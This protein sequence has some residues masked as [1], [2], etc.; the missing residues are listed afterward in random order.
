MHTMGCKPSVIDTE[1][2]YSIDEIRDNAET[3][4]L[5]LF[6][7]KGNISNCVRLFSGSV[8]SHV[9]I[10][11]KSN[12]GEVYIFECAQDDKFIDR[13]TGV[14]K[15][16]ARLVRFDDMLEMRDGLPHYDGYFIALRK[17]SWN[18]KS[19]KMNAYVEKL[20]DN[21]QNNDHT[22]VMHIFSSMIHI[23]Y[24]SDLLPLIGSTMTSDHDHPGSFDEKFCTQL[25]IEVLRAM[26][27]AEPGP[28][29]CQGPIVQPRKGKPSYKYKLD[30]FTS[31][32]GDSTESLDLLSWASY[33]REYYAT[34]PQ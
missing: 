2:L 23:E 28:I 26:F 11:F 14:R 3:G 15:R 32:Y 25:T 17:L 34:I 7:G 10:I 9:A 8:W 13:I 5:I 21:W 6:S 30:D 31:L 12:D 19:K 1:Q 20:K 33:S 24:T 29:T 4:D 27:I 18:D 16:G 22:G